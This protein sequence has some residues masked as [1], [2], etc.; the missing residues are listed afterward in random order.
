MSLIET[1]IYVIYSNYPN[2]ASIIYTQV[3][4][5]DYPIKLM[6]KRIFLDGKVTIFSVFYTT[7]P[8]GVIVLPVCSF[9]FLETK[10]KK[11]LIFTVLLVLGLFFS[12]TRAN[13][14]SGFFLLLLVYL[15]NLYRKKKINAMGMSVSILFFFSIF[16]LFMFLSDKSDLSLSVK[17][18]HI[19][20][21]M[22]LFDQNPIRYLFVGSGAG[23]LFYTTA[24]HRYTTNCEVAY[25]DLIRMFGFIPFIVMFFFMCYPILLIYNNKKNTKIENVVILLGYFLYLVIGGTNPLIVGSTG[26]CAIFMAYYLSNINI[27]K[28]LGIDF[29]NFD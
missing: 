15:I 13:I 12:G 6:G 16:I 19:E 5:K 11:Y 22:K 29:H 8:L 3:S 25:L 23:S 26:F 9:F 4:S 2:A 24:W 27:K 21:I 17:R 18:E 10:Q 28:E 20:S 1:I 7:S 14:L